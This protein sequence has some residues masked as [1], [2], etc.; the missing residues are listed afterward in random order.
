MG[1]VWAAVNEAF[2]REVAIKVMLPAVAATDP[3]AIERF[4]TEARICGS[5]RHPGIVDVIDVGRTE[6]GAPY[7]VMELLDGASL[8]TIIHRAGTLRPLDVLPVVRDVARTLSLAHEKGVVHRDL[9][10]GNVY[11]HRLPTGQI[12]AKVL[13]F[14]V[15]KVTTPAHRVDRHPRRHRRR[16]PRVHE[17]GAGR[18]PRR[19]R[20]PLGRV[21]ARRHPLRVARGAPPLPRAELQRADDR[22]RGQR[23]AHARL[24][25]ARPPQAGARAGQGHDGAQPRQPHPFGRR[26][27]RPHRGH[28]HRAGRHGHARRSPSPP[29][30]EAAARRARAPS[31]RRP[32]P[33]SPPTPA[34]GLA[35][36]RPPSSSRARRSSSP[37]SAPRR[38]SSSSPRVPPSPPARPHPPRRPH[39]RARL[40]SPPRAARRP[41]RR[42]PPHHP[43]TRPTALRRRARRAADRRTASA[44][45]SATTSSAPAQA[46]RQAGA[47]GKEEGRLGL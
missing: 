32:R 28:P 7:L 2:G 46:G 39:P 35:A 17:P 21:R 5:I 25:R 26:P 18:R 19:G 40:P 22:H 8:D 3:T 24:G 33:R 14:G 11:L 12:V 13:D 6:Q 16:L 41:P 9:K 23:P 15:S 47:L 20:R 10:P 34:S 31:R 43:R 4:F 42:L 30:S 44:A 38:G 36:S 37:P 1:V 27:R 45:A 29:R